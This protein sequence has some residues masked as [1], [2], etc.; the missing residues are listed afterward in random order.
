M[1]PAGSPADGLRSSIA[2]DPAPETLAPADALRYAD[3]VIDRRRGRIVCVREDHTRPGE[4]INTLVSVD[5]SGAVAPQV[6]VSGGDFFSTPQLGPDG[7]RLAWLTWNH[8]NMPWVTTEVWVGEILS[9]GAVGNA[10]QVAGGPDEAMFQPEW[11]PDG[12]LYFISDRGRALSRQISIGDF[13]RRIRPSALLIREQ[14]QWSSSPPW[15]A[16]RQYR[17]Y[18]DNAPATGQGASIAFSFSHALLS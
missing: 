17:I 5:I 9:N 15:C 12:D 14:K 8:P 11:S 6:L 10:R 18:S 1:L 4:A 3:G 2:T 13:R 16:S 7:E